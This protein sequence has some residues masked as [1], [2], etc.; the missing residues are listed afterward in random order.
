[1]NCILISELLFKI[2]PEKKQDLLLNI[3]QEKLL[4][5]KSTHSGFSLRTAILMETPPPESPN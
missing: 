3:L 4:R 5:L 1:M 2:I